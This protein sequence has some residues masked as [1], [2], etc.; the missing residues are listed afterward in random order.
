MTRIAFACLIAL[1][2]TI[3]PAAAQ[4]EQMIST[5][6]SLD[7]D[8]ACSQTPDTDDEDG[9]GAELWCDG[10]QGIAVRVVEGDL[11]FAL[12]YGRNAPDQCSS[13]QTLGPFHTIG[14]TLEWRVM[15]EFPGHLTPVATILRYKTEADGKTGEYLVVTRLDRTQACHM[16]YV[17]VRT[18]KNANALARLAA[19]RYGPAFDCARD[20]AFMMTA[21]GP[22]AGETPGTGGCE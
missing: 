10:W 20:R 3:G 2:A 6:S 11:R 1:G 22:A 9:I 19:D 14:K 18:Q 12:G 21:A 7:F 16:A 15:R 4:D 5:Y 8:K 17:D 13:Q